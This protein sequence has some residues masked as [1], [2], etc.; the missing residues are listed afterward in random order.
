MSECRQLMTEKIL[1]TFCPGVMIYAIRMFPSANLSPSIQVLQPSSL[2]WSTLN[3]KFIA[4]LKFPGSSCSVFGIFF[5]CLK[6]RTE[7]NKIISLLSIKN[8]GRINLKSIHGSLWSITETTDNDV[9]MLN[10]CNAAAQ[11][12]SWIP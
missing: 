4:M 1:I 8:V 5:K 12:R 3:A 2:S 11:P 10:F 7:D 6:L 9:G